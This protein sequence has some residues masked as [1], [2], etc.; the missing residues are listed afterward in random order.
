MWTDDCRFANRSQAVVG[1]W[2]QASDV[3][4]RL[5][6]LWD[7]LSTMHP[8]AGGAPLSPTVVARVTLGF[9]EQLRDGIASRLLRTSIA[10][11]PRLRIV[12]ALEFVLDNY[13]RATLIQADVARHVGIS[14]G[15]LSHVLAT[16]TG[17]TYETH[18]HGI[19]VLRASLL[20]RDS[21]DS[22]GEIATQV[23]YGSLT[24]LERHFRE[25]VGMTPMEFR[26]DVAAH[27]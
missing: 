19:R 13:H 9:A 22:I 1:E 20:L 3:A 7:L 8:P 27:R 15:H 17:W 26:L 14:T 4:S 25:W 23:G 10:S 24:A 2:L 11:Q 5:S 21:F 12:R 18:L 16:Q 6:S